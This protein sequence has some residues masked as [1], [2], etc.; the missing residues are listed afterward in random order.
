MTRISKKIVHSLILAGEIAV[1]KDFMLS[2]IAKYEKDLMLLDSGVKYSELGISER[3][4][5]TI[6]KAY[7]NGQTTN[8]DDAEKGSVAIHKLSGMMRL[9]DGLSSYGVRTLADQMIKADSN[10]NISFHLIDVNSGGGFSTA[11]QFLQNT[12]VDLKKPTIAYVHFAGS[13]A[14]MAIVPCDSIV[15]AGSMSRMGSIGVYQSIDKDFVKWYE[16]NYDDIYS[17]TSPDKNKELRDY[18]KGDK[19]TLIKQV[20]KS[21]KV[22][23]SQVQDFRN[24][25]GDVRDTLNGGVFL[26][27]ESVERGLGDVVGTMSDAIDIGESI[28]ANKKSNP[29]FNNLLSALNQKLFKGNELPAE[30]TEDQLLE[31]INNF[32][33]SDSKANDLNEKLDELSEKFNLLEKSLGEKMENLSNRIDNFSK[34]DETIKSLSSSME[35]MEVKIKNLSKDKAQEK[36]GNIR[37]PK[38]SK[39][40]GLNIEQAAASGGFEIEV[41]VD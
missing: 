9:E 10:P 32:D 1:D 35:G 40:A 36:A 6:S 28:L 26:A 25:K 38:A 20:T 29:M 31:A 15:L 33:L 5:S 30:T 13:A 19:E 24:L 34:E 39:G 22:F 14:V 4:S 8:L 18:M 7:N 12:I 23:E 37:M 16:D 21:D 2:E 11:G 3:R 17:E 41:E 27:S